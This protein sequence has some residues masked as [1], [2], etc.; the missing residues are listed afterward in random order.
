MSSRSFTSSSSVDDDDEDAAL[1]RGGG[2]GANARVVASPYRTSNAT[3]ER[4]G[5]GGMPKFVLVLVLV[6]PP[7]PVGTPP[8]K[9]GAGC[10]NAVV[11]AA[12]TTHTA[13]VATSA[14]YD[15]NDDVVF[16]V[17]VVFG[18][19]VFV[20]VAGLGIAT[21]ALGG[22]A[23]DDDARRSTTRFSSVARRLDVMLILCPFLLRYIL[24]LVQCAHPV[25]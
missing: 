19:V 11:V 21:M 20:V 10:W 18:V 7:A 9:A 12:A 24:L 22:A 23:R 16:F 3:R 2:G 6:S 4:Y 14:M 17:V 5:P 15:A 1:A 25:H 8:K 13:V